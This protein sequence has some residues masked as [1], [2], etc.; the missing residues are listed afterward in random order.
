MRDA[1]TSRERVKRTLHFENPDRAPRDLWALPGVVLY[2]R[3]EYDAMLERFPSDF[4]GP[5]MNYGLSERAKPMQGKTGTYVDEWGCLWEVAEP[6]V[7]GEVKQPILDDWSALK[8]Y[9][10]PWEVLDNADTSRVNEACAK[11]DL[12]V[13]TGTHVRPFERIQF[14]RGSEN[15]FMD[16]GYD[17]KEMHQLLEMIHDFNLRDMRMWAKTDVDGV[18]FMD[19]W[20]TQISLLISPRQ[21]REVFKP[22]YKE[23]CEILRAAGKDVWFHSDGHIE[24][25]YPD[26][27]EIGIH[28]V[29]SQLFCMDI[30]GL[31]ARHKGQVTFWG[32]IDRQNIMPRGTADDVRE[33]VRRVRKALDDGRGGVIA[34]CEWGVTD[35][36]ENVATVFETWLE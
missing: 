16:L 13:R 18:S 20:G 14:L 36:G 27:I 34:E 6:G 7:V 29:N 1:M 21:W 9:Q 12:Y 33:A 19:D 23:Y 31:A 26:L 24:A 15:L 30:E 5:D 17:A 22:L 10:P 32:E 28:S 3:D 35:P 8:H 4:V 11:T 2:R 25:I